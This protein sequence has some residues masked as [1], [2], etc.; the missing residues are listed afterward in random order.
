MCNILLFLWTLIYILCKLYAN[1][2]ELIYVSPCVMVYWLL[3]QDVHTL[4]AMIVHLDFKQYRT[5]YW[6]NQTIAHL[7]IM[8][9]TFMLTFRLRVTLTCFISDLKNIKALSFAS[10]R[11]SLFVQQYGIFDFGLKPNLHIMQI[12]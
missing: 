4:L 12:M 9:S 1:Y 8:Q 10:T 7:H 5:S 2:V 11:S 3:I 6:S